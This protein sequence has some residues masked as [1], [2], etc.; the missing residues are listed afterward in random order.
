M[1][2]TR[3]ILDLLVPACWLAISILSIRLTFA[4]QKASSSNIAEVQWPAVGSIRSI[5]TAEVY[6]AKHYNVGWSPT[7]TALGVPPRG[8]EPSAK[9]A[10]LLDNSL[11]CGKKAN[12]IFTYR[13]GKRD[14]TGKITTYTLS[15]RP[16]KWHEGLWNFFDDDT[17]VIRGTT[18]DR[19]ARA[20]DPPI[21]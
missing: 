7:L 18:E 8:I 3:K 21:Q 16:V 4:A 20:S 5:N 2:R 17:G 9:A 1:K 10:G 13:A 6:Y 14:A 15:V 11:T 12:H 19:A